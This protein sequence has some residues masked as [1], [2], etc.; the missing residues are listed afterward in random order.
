M[1]YLSMIKNGGPVM[2]IIVGCSIVAMFI[3][4]EK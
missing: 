1:E 4:V 2:F 3:F